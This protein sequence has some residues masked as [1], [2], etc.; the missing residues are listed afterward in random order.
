MLD[1]LPDELM[2]MIS[3]H[4]NLRDFLNFSS[5]NRRCYRLSYDHQYIRNQ[6]KALNVYDYVEEN[7][8]ECFQFYKS[9]AVRFSQEMAFFENKKEEVLTILNNLPNEHR[10]LVGVLKKIRTCVN[11]LEHNI[12][13]RYILEADRMLNAL[14]QRLIFKQLLNFQ[15]TN[16]KLSC[17]T[18]IP[19]KVIEMH[20]NALKSITRLELNGNG[21]ESVSSK[22]SLCDQLRSL[23]LYDNPI[24]YLPKNLADFRSLEYLYMSQ[25]NLS[26]LPPSFFQLSNLKWVSLSNMKLKNLSSEIKQLKQLT[27]LNLMGNQLN[28]LPIELTQL[29]HLDE[30]YLHNNCLPLTQPPEIFHYLKQKKISLSSLLKTQHNQSQNIQTFEEPNPQDFKYLNCYKKHRNNTESFNR[31]RELD[32]DSNTLERRTKREKPRS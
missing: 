29:E 32:L 8:E 14:N 7:K 31:L 27:W 18:R 25:G 30:V 11:H 19:D 4:F 20:H 17:I 3:Q 9:R 6:L 28:T 5:V 2:I 12:D 23:N 10:C 13:K 24:T 21:L 26:T 1:L 22:L 16:L 15:G